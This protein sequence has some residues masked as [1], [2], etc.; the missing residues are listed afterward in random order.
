MGVGEVGEFI[1]G[2]AGME[3]DDAV[4]G[5]MHPEHGARVFGKGALVVGKVRAVGGAHFPERCAAALH[6]VGNAEAAA[7]FHKLPAG[8]QY[9]AALAQRVQHEQHGRGVVVHHERRLG[10]GEGAEQLFH[11]A[12]AAAA[13]SGFEVEFQIAVAGRGN[14]H[15]F[16]CLFGQHGAA[17]IGV[18]HHA[19]PVDDP[20]QPGPVLAGDERFKTGLHGARAQSGFV[21]H[22]AGADVFAQ[23][24]EQGAGAF[25]K[26][27]V[28]RGGKRFLQPAETRVHRWKRAEK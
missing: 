6:D 20:A 18:N 10:S 11:K 1:G 16:L 28:R 12:D 27:A 8:K 7:Y 22:A 3:A 17:E 14:V 4:V 9:F 5:R 25:Q 26:H 23:F 13:L 24:V 21:R 15:G 19:C 2:H